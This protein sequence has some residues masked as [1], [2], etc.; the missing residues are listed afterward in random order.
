MPQGHLAAK[1]DQELNPKSP[2][3]SVADRVA[4]A[5]PVGPC[6]QRNQDE[7]DRKQQDHLDFDK[8]GLKPGVILGVV[9]VVNTAG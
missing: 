6:D 1:T 9:L 4:D 2:Q 5:E 8:F 3:N 7:S